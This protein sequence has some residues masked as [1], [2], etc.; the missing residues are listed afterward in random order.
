MRIYFA[1]INA[2]I[3]DLEANVSAIEAAADAARRERCDVVLTPELAVLGYPPLDLLERRELLTACASMATRLAEASRGLTVIVGNA[4]AEPPRADGAI[5]RPAR[6]VAQV[7]QDGRALTTITKRLLPSYDVFDEDR[8]FAP[9]D[10]APVVTIAGRQVGITICEDIW[11]DDELGA[12][13]Y[14][15]DPVDDLVAAGAD[16]I[17]NLSASPFDLGKAARRLALVR[18]IARDHGVP[19][20][21]C[22]LVGG[23]DA[24][25]FD[26]RSFAI[27]GRGEVLGVAAAFA[28]DAMVLTLPDAVEPG[29]AIASAVPPELAPESADEA[30]AALVLGVRDYL[31]KC[32]FREVVIGLSGGIDSAVTAAI[33]VEALGADAVLGVAMPGPHSSDH[34]VRDALDLAER[35]GIRCPV[36]PISPI[37]ASLRDALADE[38]A[39]PGRDSGGVTL[40]NLQARARGVILMGVSNHT[41]RLLLTTGNKSELAVGYCTLYGDMNGGLAV[42]GDLPKMLVYAVART[43]NREGEVIPWSTIEK[44]PSAEL[45]PDQK[46]EDSLPPYP[47]LD[48][49][50][51]RYLVHR[52]GVDGIVAA[53]G[54]DRALAQRIVRLVEINEYKRRQAAPVLRVTRKAFGGGRRIP[55]ARAMPPRAI[56]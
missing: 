56:A 1:Q 19:V 45:A 54:C 13:R 3:A 40:Q 17:L 24:L 38:M 33:A 31:G 46:D 27:D 55:M 39:R 11:S 26:G 2:T 41:G 4:I 21:Y 12:R 52:D 14:A 34:S 43:Y 50:L 29:E 44:P 8:Y 9:G 7:F 48:A 47:L 22:N 5:P 25:I 23:N 20:A 35:L 32:G 28:A 36:V 18:G 30:R 37:Y 6:N 51:E 16:C 15:V 49:M 53:T 10:A 42:I